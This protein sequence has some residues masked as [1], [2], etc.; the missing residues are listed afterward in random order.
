MLR[1]IGRVALSLF[2][3]LIVLIMVVVFGFPVDPLLEIEASSYSKTDSLELYSANKTIP[4]KYRNQV[5][6]ALS[7]FPELIPVQIKFELTG[8]GAPLESNFSIPTLFGPKEGRVYRIL[9]VEQEG[10]PYDP[11]LVRNLP[12]ESQ[13][14]ILAHELCHT[15]YYEKLNSLQIASWGLRYLFL[16]S[17]AK[18]HER[19]TDKLT[20]L[21]GFGPE[22]LQYAR[23]VRE[24]PEFK[25]A[26][27]SGELKWIDEYYLPPYEIE[28]VLK[29]IE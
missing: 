5:L 25:R 14:A 12:S 28:S 23:Y 17:F 3:F 4:D 10:G 29:Q 7:H 9:I 11:V 18:Q 6:T 19:N 1:R 15:I 24:I 27:E 20:I 22:L 8:A 26:Y 13:V 16:D 2:T 21:K